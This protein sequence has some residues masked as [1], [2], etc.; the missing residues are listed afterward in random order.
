MN[1]QEINKALPKQW[2]DIKANSVEAKTMDV[3]T[4]VADELSSELL[5]I[6]DN[7][8][9]PNPPVGYVSFYSTGSEFKS[10]DPLGN[11]ATFLTTAMPN[12]YASQVELDQV[13]SQS[14][15]L[16]PAGQRDLWQYGT[17][18]LGSGMIYSSDFDKIWTFGNTAGVAQYST[19]GGATFANCVFDVVSA[20]FIYIGSNS[21]VV[22]ALS[23]DGKNA[24]TSPDGINFTS[25]A[26]P[27]AGITSF[28]INWFA[29]VG[30][31]IAGAAVDAT[32]NI[33]T[34]PDGV[35]WTARVSTVNH[36]TVIKSNSSLCVATCSAA[37]YVM[38]S[39][40]GIVWTNTITP[41][42]A[43]A[44]A[45]AWSEEQ[46]MW[47]CTLVAGLTAYTSTDGLSWTSRGTLTPQLPGDSLIWVGNGI[48]RWYG[49]IEDT[50][51]NYSL[52]SSPVA[53]SVFIGAKLDGALT[54]NL[55]YSLAYDS[56]R[57]RFYMGVNVA[58]FFAYCTPRPLD[59]KAFSDNIRVRGSAVDA[60]LFS[61]YSNV[62]VNNTI[63]ETSLTSGSLLGTKTLQDPLAIGMMIDFKI[64]LST[65][66][67]AGDTLTIRIKSGATTLHTIAMTI[68]AGA[69]SLVS[70]LNGT[71]IVQA[72]TIQINSENFTSN[73]SD[74][75][76]ASNAAFNPNVTNTLEVTAQWGANVNSCTMIGMVFNTHFRN[77]A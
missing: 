39:P 12:D 24:Y 67:V 71:M 68:P 42:T 58:P 75:L 16:A 27:P 38:S 6:K 74:K 18:A 36:P 13:Q 49:A 52:V 63:A 10:V 50:S 8:S 31:F 47:M 45:L 3:A 34:S 54:N 5:S 73:V 9:V 4:L 64:Y 37:P 7:A 66:S 22:V 69:A 23:D 55:P 51:G 32:H 35:V 1:L 26:V 70:K 60:S 30:L 19:N 56:G 2:L 43:A 65:T 46:K 53:T 61:S 29:S 14:Q 41:L 57:N 11:E 17:G 21:T 28:T 72:A 48:N 44:R 59:V 25:V 15:V 20:G 76:Q 40:D 33:I 62:S 77:G